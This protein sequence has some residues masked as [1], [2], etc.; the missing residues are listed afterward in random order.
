MTD[1]STAPEN[2][3]AWDFMPDKQNEWMLGGWYDKYDR[4][5][6]EY[7]RKDLC[8]ALQAQLDLIEQFTRDDVASEYEGQQAQLATARDDAL[9][10]ADKAICELAW[11]MPLEGPETLEHEVVDTTF[12]EAVLAI[13][14]LKTTNSNS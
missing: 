2:I 3:W 6:T 14:A 10:E 7:V 8:D 1:T 12:R 5:A 13:R 4:K 9:D 11:P